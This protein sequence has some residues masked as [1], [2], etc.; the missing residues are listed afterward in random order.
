MKMNADLAEENPEDLKRRLA[1]K[2]VL[3]ESPRM[4]TTNNEEQPDVDE[5]DEDDD[6]DK[7]KVGSSSVCLCLIDK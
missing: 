1:Q 4:L 5:E 7:V 3:D 6:E 2:A